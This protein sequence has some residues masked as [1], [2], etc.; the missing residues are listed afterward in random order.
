MAE[1]MVVVIY[2]KA[3]TLNLPY[4]IGEGKTSSVKFHKFLPGKN[5][6]PQSIWESIKAEA[7]EERMDNHS[8]YMRAIEATV[9][10]ETGKLDFESLKTAAEMIEL[11][12]NIMSLEELEQVAEFENARPQPR[13]TVLSAIEKQASEVQ[14][15]IDKVKAG[16]E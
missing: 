5:E 15:F 12:E 13:K 10:E 2:N 11:V 3:N 9:D 14:A 1:K 6:V 16:E 4:R 7:G 8:R